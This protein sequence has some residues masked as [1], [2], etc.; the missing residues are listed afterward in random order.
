MDFNSGKPSHIFAFLLLIGS[1]LLIFAVP[2]VTFFAVINS[3]QLIEDLDV[4]EISAFIS[5]LLVIFVFVLVPFAWYFIVNKLVLKQILTRIK[6]VSQ[7]IDRAF[8]WGILA[9]IVIFILIFIIEVILIMLGQDPQDLS[10]IPDIQKLFSWPTIFLLV[11]IQPIGEEIFFRG[12]LFEKIEKYSGGIPA[13]F[14]TAFLFGIAHMSY[15]KIFPVIMPMIM[16]VILGFIVLKTKNLYSS[17]IAHVAFNVT[18][19]TLAFL[20]WEL[21][22]NIA[23]IL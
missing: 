20:G 15:G 18:S 5:Q 13:I 12:F 10:N 22:E 19:L 8:L 9:A 14:F 11:T 23:L 1:F 3:P 21:L 4:S 17:I 2:I 16:G 6:L 7:N